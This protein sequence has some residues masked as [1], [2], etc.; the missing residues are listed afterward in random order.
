MPVDTDTVETT[1]KR[2]DNDMSSQSIQEEV[3]HQELFPITI[4]YTDNDSTSRK[5][6]EIPDI[7]NDSTSMS[8]IQSNNF[9]EKGRPP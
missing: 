4:P 2:P 8:N 3:Q 5:K 1:D 6:I 7:D 9:I